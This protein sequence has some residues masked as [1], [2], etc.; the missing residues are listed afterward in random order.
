VIFE[1]NLQY[2]H[3]IVDR[4][5]WSAEWK[6]IFEWIGPGQTVLE[7]GC[8]TGDFSRWLKQ[9]GCVITGLELNSKALEVARPFLQEA[10]CGDIESAD[11]MEQLSAKKFDVIL[12]EHVLEHLTDPWRVLAGAKKLLAP[13]GQVIIALPNIS[14][15]QNRLE[16]FAG[17]FNYSSIGVMDKTHL[18]FFNQ[19]TARE[20]I[21]QA[22][23]KVDE[24]ASPWRV[25]PVRQFVDHLPLLNRLRFLLPKQP[26][27]NSFYSRNLT[28][29]VMLFRCS[30]E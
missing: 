1:E 3:T 26:A 19:K 8:H 6:I 24:Y 2:Q 28:D 7:A 27:K 20:L 11:V 25:N 4:S 15:A 18:R 17:R 10:I 30:A 12:F 16:M 21:T 14:N 13:G 5:E 23:L 29:V 9:A 22:G